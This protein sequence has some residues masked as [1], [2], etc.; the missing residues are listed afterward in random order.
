MIR[1]VSSG[2][3]NASSGLLFGI[4][5]WGQGY[6]SNICLWSHFSVFPGD[7]YMRL[8]TGLIREKKIKRTE[9]WV[10]ICF[11]LICISQGAGGIF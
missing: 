7:L 8:A 11:L 2:F 4:T 3:R 9:N 10:R 5:L 6:V 1:S